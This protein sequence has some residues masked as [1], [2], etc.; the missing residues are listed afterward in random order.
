MI[1]MA[2]GEATLDQFRVAYMKCSRLVGWFRTNRA[3]LEGLLKTSK[4]EQ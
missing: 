1:E 2:D 3:S 4:L